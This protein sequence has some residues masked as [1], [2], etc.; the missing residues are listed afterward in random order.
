MTLPSLNPAL[1][2]SVCSC[3]CLQ[4]SFPCIWGRQFMACRPNSTPRLLSV[5][6]NKLWLVHSHTLSTVLSVN[7]FAGQWQAWIVRTETTWAAKPKIF[8]IR[9][10]SGKKKKKIANPSPRL[11]SGWFYLVTQNRCSSQMFK[12]R[13]SLTVHPRIAPCHKSCHLVLWS[14]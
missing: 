5:S 13:S 14:L 7:A 12:E 8:T 6:I 4:C 9:S 11:W 2:T 10:F 1:S 3:P